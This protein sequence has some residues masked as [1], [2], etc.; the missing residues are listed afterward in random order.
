MMSDF[1]FFLEWYARHPFLG[2]LLILIF[3]GL[4]A[5]CAGSIAR[6]FRRNDDET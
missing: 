2:I 1:A 3:A 6:I 5:S 4:I